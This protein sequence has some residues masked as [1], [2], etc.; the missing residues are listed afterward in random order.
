MDSI[1]P[2]IDRLENIES[3]IDNIIETK[4]SL[5]LRVTILESKNGNRIHELELAVALV[6]DRLLLLEHGAKGSD[7]RWEKV[8]D[9]GWKLVV[10]VVGGY[11]LLQL[12]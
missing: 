8:F 12:K 11:L 9:V 6:R 3:K 1:E 2:I 10:A 5:D 7:W 4:H